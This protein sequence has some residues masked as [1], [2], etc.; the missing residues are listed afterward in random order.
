MPSLS[1]MIMGETSRLNE[2]IDRPGLIARSY[3]DDKEKSAK[4]KAGLA[5]VNEELQMKRRQNMDQAARV[6]NGVPR[7]TMEQIV[8][9]NTRANEGDTDARTQRDV[10]MKG[11]FSNPEIV[12][13]ISAHPSMLSLKDLTY[14]D[15]YKMTPE[16]QQQMF[17]LIPQAYSN[18]DRIE[19][20]RTLREGATAK[21]IARQQ[22]EATSEGTE[23]GELKGQDRA[24]REGLTSGISERTEGQQTKVQ[25]SYGT[26][27]QDKVLSDIGK[28]FFVDKD[29]SDDGEFAKGIKNMPTEQFMLDAPE[30]EDLL[31]VL[32]SEDWLKG[33]T[34][35]DKNSLI[36]QVL[37]QAP[38]GTLAPQSPL[39]RKIEELKNVKLKHIRQ[40]PK[41]IVP[42]STI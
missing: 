25:G 42:R 17:S 10:M 35:E 34:D 21:I 7:Q 39:R 13:S 38:E 37:E 6:S 5:L 40:A 8:Y 1:D 33:K 29:L 31:S 3:K 4:N 16:E 19:K 41:A 20:E 2:A 11:V 27:L 12:A 18:Y 14:D 23:Y 28:R 22:A 32:T 26:Y 30:F 24:R 36:D 9:L 15:Y